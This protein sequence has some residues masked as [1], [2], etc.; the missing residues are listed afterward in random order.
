MSFFSEHPSN[1]ELEQNY[2]KLGEKNL[3]FSTII[4]KKL[5][6]KHKHLVNIIKKKKFKPIEI[7]CSR[8]GNFLLALGDIK[9]HRLVGLWPLEV[10]AFLHTVRCREGKQQLELSAK[11]TKVE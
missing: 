4:P 8:A 10:E 11:Y 1:D 7:G 9:E 5:Q 2:Q 3:L 6:D